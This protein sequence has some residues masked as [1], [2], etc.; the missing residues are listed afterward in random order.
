MVSIDN[1][2]EDSKGMRQV[3][4]LPMAI[5][6]SPEAD[7]AAKAGMKRTGEKEEKQ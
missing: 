1:S 2:S 4:P 5:F 3:S 6:Y 7:G